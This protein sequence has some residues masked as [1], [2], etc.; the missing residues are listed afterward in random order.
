VVSAVDLVRGIGRCAGLDVLL[1]PGTTG[2]LDTNYEGK[3]AYLIDALESGADFGYLH[4]EAPDETGHEGRP[5]LKVQAV[6]DF[7]ARVVGP[8][9]AYADGRGDVRLVVGPD[10]VTSLATRTHAGGPVP[11]AMAGPGIAPDGVEC[12]DEQSAEAGGLLVEAGHLLIPHWL[13]ADRIAAADLGA[14][15]AE[16]PAS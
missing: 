14:L 10:H 8:I 13:G 5:D 7:D 15:R 9:T 4:V 12:Y 6:A 1:V 11:F 3:V 2:Y 16:T